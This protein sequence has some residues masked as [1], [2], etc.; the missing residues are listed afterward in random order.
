MITA[1][2]LRLVCERK[3]SDLIPA[4]QPEAGRDSFRPAQEKR[5]A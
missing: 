2:T 3:I 5:S 1:G 4:D